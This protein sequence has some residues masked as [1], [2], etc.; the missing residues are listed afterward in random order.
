LKKVKH[1]KKII[2]FLH[3]KLKYLI[4]GSVLLG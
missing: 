3:I 1:L 2:S 4:K